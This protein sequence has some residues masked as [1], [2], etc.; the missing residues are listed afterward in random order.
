MVGGYWITEGSFSL[1]TVPKSGHFIPANYY[2]ASR[3]YLDDFVEHKALQCH[4]ESCKV[5][6]Q[7]CS[8]MNN[9]SNNGLCNADGQCQCHSPMFKGADCSQVVLGNRDTIF[10]G[11]GT[12]WAY[13]MP[14]MT[15]DHWRFVL[16]SN[17]PFDVYISQR[18]GAHSNPNQFNYDSSFLN[19]TP[20]RNLTIRPDMLTRDGP[21]VVALKSNAYDFA[22]NTPL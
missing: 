3:S 17:Q 4:S 5:T 15:G 19:V 13:F 1:L 9:C 16:T 11:I 6:D 22:T 21:V 20:G 2:E 8:F 18:D 7:M 10:F 14:N 12:Q